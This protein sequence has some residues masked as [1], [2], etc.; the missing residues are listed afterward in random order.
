MKSI[1]ATIIKVAIF[2]VVMLLGLVLIMQA[3]TRPVT[4][5]LDS[6]HGMF[7]DVSGLKVG[8]DVRMLGVQVGKVTHVGVKQSADHRDTAAQVD[9]TV[10]NSHKLP[11]GTKLAIRYQNL[12]G[13]RYV[14]LETPA[15]G[16]GAPLPSGATFSTSDTIPSF[17]I[18]SVFNGLKPV[19]ATLATSDIN[20]LAQSILAVVQG[21]GNGIGPVL[22]SVDKL[23]SVS[24]D[25]QRV[26]TTLISN[27]GQISQ[28]IDGNS[29]GLARVL[30]DLDVFSRSLAAGSTEIRQWSDTTSGV[31]RS[32]NGFL[33]ALGLTPDTNPAL[34]AVIANALPTAEQVVDVL[35][36][37]PGLISLL[38]SVMAQPTSKDVD[39]KCT[40]GQAS[41]PGLMNVFVAGQRITVCNP[42]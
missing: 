41:L 26:L 37:I 29:P 42:K 40:K 33:A 31:V 21:N 22:E 35:A 10:Q 25:R 5:K 32:A 3:L 6:F 27:L 13:S 23:V 20:H 14:D 28:Q 9:F 1:R 19:L 17:D 12:T 24:N 16:G 39:L 7:K 8:D 15:Q 4:G 11:S 30:T 2:A 18:T 34:D 36:D 38:N